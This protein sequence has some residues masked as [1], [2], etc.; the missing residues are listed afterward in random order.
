MRRFIGVFT[1]KRAKGYWIVMNER[2][3][4]FLPALLGQSNPESGIPACW[5]IMSL[6]MI[7]ELEMRHQ[8]V[9]SVL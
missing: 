6:S 8:G 2:R 3:K 5:R 1:T 9:R 4:K 7:T